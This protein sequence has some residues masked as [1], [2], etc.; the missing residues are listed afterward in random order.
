MVRLV[1]LGGSQKYLKTAFYGLTGLLPSFVLLCVCPLTGFQDM[2]RQHLAVTLALGL[3]LGIV[4]TKVSY[5]FRFYD[6]EMETFQK[7]KSTGIALFGIGRNH[8]AKVHCV[9]Y[10]SKPS[11]GQ[12]PYTRRFFDEQKVLKPIMHI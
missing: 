2:S 1:D 6:G 12:N 9:L 4:V 3:P 5:P 7:A 10:L 11:S 8:H